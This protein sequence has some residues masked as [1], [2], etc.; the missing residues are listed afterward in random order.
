MTNTVEAK[1]FNQMWKYLGNNPG[2][3]FKKQAA[4]WGGGV[5]LQDWI[6]YGSQKMGGGGGGGKEDYLKAFQ[7]FEKPEF[8]G[9][10]H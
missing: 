9:H 10:I 6:K 3:D 7:F 1:H 8:P 2:E 5:N 4:T